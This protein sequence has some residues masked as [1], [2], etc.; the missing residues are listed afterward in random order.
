MTGHVDSSAEEVVRA[1]AAAAA[2][3]RLYPPTSEIPAQ[4]IARFVSVAQTATAVGKTPV[5]FIVEPKTFRVGEQ[6]IG[7]GQAQIGGLAE[8]L[9]A[10][11]A[12]Q[13]IIAPV[14]T[15][16]ETAAF[17]RCV[18]SDTAAV[19]EEGGLRAVVGAA[20]VTGIAVVELTLR[21]AADDGLA[22]MDLTSAPLEAI[23]PA[24]VRAAAA[25]AKSAATG[26]GR[27]EM[28]EAIG[29]MPSAA[30]E[31][32]Q[33]RV[34]QALMQMD[35]QTRTAVLAAAIRQDASGQPMEGMLSVIASMK[36]AM[37]ARLLSLT[38][39]RTGSE[40][41][42]LATKLQ[43]PPEALRALELLLRPSQRTES[44]S[45]VPPR[46]DAAEIAGEAITETDDDAAC[47]DAARRTLQQTEAA[48]RGLLTTLRV[49]QRSPDAD[50]LAALAEAMPR[51]L[52]AGALTAVRS[53]LSALDGL[54][55]RPD[56]EPEVDRVRQSIAD[57]EHLAEGLERVETARVRDTADV[58]AAAGP[59]GAEALVRVWAHADEA[60]RAFLEEVARTVPDQVIAT[61]SR[62]MRAADATEVRDLVGLLGRLRDRRALSTLSQALDNDARAVRTAAVAALAELGSDD[63]WA[64]IVS[65]LTHPD[66]ETALAALRA[67]R[68]ADRRRAIPAMVAV[69][70]LHSGAARNHDLKREIMEDMGRWQA[71]EAMPVLKRM[72]GR[73]FAFGRAA[74]ELRDLARRA[75]SQIQAAQAVDGG[76]VRP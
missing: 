76:K 48:S 30:R 16:D 51:S 34:A 63:A 15:A 58:L 56:L 65:A 59:A 69:L 39:S 33:E 17:L 55:Q 67:I 21:S 1:L 57:V 64:A 66:Q 47:L 23:A 35:E 8:A 62:R 73:R 3:V 7:D 6:V 27:D 5:R 24:I 25:W 75:M 26:H 49:I 53:A 14:V 43:L 71:V 10:H 70:Q 74:R 42:D 46:V 28:G 11:Q 50:G 45:G 4:T 31:L 52:S 13:I 2:A 19:R 72:A 41:G 18:A 61:V 22:T 20:G 36:P 32:A 68:A 40:P 29:G 44:E 37:L 12:G 60:R 54:S 38:A 9:Y